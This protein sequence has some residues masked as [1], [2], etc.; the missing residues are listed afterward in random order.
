MF[1]GLL[2]RSKDE[3]Q[4]SVFVIGDNLSDATALADVLRAAGYNVGVAVENEDSIVALEEEGLPHAFIVDFATPDVDARRFVEK[5][6]IRFGRSKVPPILM[7]M[8]TP[9]QEATA[10]QMQVED[11]LPKPYDQQSLLNHLNGLMTSRPQ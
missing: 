5:A 9:D 3:P 7:L 2:K 1:E 4:R 10:N 6:R 11:C 8:A